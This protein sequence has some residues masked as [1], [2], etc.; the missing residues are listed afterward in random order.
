MGTAPRR[1]RGRSTP[2][3]LSALVLTFTAGC[4]DGS[5]TAPAT[6][7]AYP[8]LS[9][10][11][12]TAHF[13]FHMAP[14]D[15]VDDARQE[16]FHAWFTERIGIR[17]ARR[18]EYFKYRSLGHMEAVGPG[19]TGNGWADVEVPAIHSIYGYHSHEAVHVYTYVVGRP[20]DYFNEGMAMAWSVD[21]LGGDMTPR[22]NNVPIH[23]LAR[24]ARQGGGLH[25]VATIATTDA[26]RSIPDGE[27][28]PQAGSFVRFLCDRYGVDPVLELFRRGSRED[29]L[30]SVRAAF[31]H[32]F[33]MSLGDAERAW[34][35]FLDAL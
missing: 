19:Q 13:S 30:S 20:T 33:G 17:M 18:I 6:P 15:H 3:L 35:E 31:R 26:F 23:E 10:I 7:T 9:E 32:A 24:R 4:S 34:H 11:V 16:A 27:G 5:P 28:Y 25:A 21:P 12:T 29:S 8:P 14:G 2:V 22:W 1:R